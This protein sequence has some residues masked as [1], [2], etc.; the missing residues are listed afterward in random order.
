M[1]TRPSELLKLCRRFGQIW[2][3]ATGVEVDREFHI[4]GSSDARRLGRWGR[5]LCLLAGEKISR[6]QQSTTPYTM[7]Q[8]RP[9]RQQPTKPTATACAIPGVGGAH[10]A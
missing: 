1:P 3:D 4:S 5:G 10:F 9:P 6:G 7:A 8:Q 2:R